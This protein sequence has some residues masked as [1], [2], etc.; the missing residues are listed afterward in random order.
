MTEQ[1]SSTQLPVTISNDFFEVFVDGPMSVA[2]VNTIAVLT[3]TRVRPKTEAAV[4]GTL[5]T[6]FQV[7]AVCRVTMPVHV[8]KDMADMLAKHQFATTPTAGS[9]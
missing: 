3:L 1:V 7:E 6:E 4:Q 2:N 5:T 8:L 9:A